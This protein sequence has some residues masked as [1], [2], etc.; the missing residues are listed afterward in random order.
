M[1]TA[2]PARGLLIDSP[3]MQSPTAA[4]GSKK[5]SHASVLLI[6]AIHE[7]NHLYILRS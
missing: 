7:K 2:P 1:R 3:S 5:T 4:A 6:G